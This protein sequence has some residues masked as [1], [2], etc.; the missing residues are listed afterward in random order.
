LAS[1]SSI[2]LEVCN[3]I[4]RHWYFNQYFHE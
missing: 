3:F 4:T 2:N 1:L